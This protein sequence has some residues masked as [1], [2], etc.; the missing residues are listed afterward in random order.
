MST[1]LLVLG[2][3]HFVGA[4]VVQDA[5][6]RGWEVTAFSRGETGEI[7]PGARHVRGDRTRAEDLRPVAG[8]DWDAV[9]DTW[10]GAAR[11]VRD[12]AGA[13]AGRAG[14]YGYVSSRSVYLDVTAGEEGATWDASPDDG[15]T[16]Y[17]AMKAGGERAALEAF[18][19]R[20]LIARA[21]LILGPREDVGRLP[22][23]LA[24]IARGGRVLAPGPRDLPLQLIDARDLAAWMLDMAGAGRGGTF[25][26]VGRRGAATM[27]DVLETCV[28]VTGSD[29]ELAWTDPVPILAAGVEPW[30]DLPIWIPPGHEWAGMH[31]APVEK[32][33]AAG[34]LTRPVAETVADTWAWMQAIGGA[35]TQRPDRPG[36]GITADVEAAILAAAAERPA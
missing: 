35:P 8:E 22:W 10:S 30:N 23:W 31:D 4:A 15:E 36:P 6:G 18:G 21:G 26:A 32:A 25:N 28:A 20:A 16:D 34:L 9:L 17:G 2:G 27:G 7:P 5:L 3:G 14:H 12:S 13:L 11:V 29:A 33:H 1:R 19:E 24:R